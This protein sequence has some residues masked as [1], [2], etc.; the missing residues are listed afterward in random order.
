M[1]SLCPTPQGHLHN[2]QNMTKYSQLNIVSWIQPLPLLDVE[3]LSPENLD[4]FVGV[5]CHCCLSLVCARKNI[6]WCPVCQWQTYSSM[7]L[8]IS[9]VPLAH[10]DHFVFGAFG[11]LESFGSFGSF[12]RFFFSSFLSPLSPSSPGFLFLPRFSTFSLGTS[13]WLF[14]FRSS[15]L[16]ASLLALAWQKRFANVYPKVQPLTSW[17]AIRP[18]C[19]QRLCS[20]F[21]LLVSKKCNN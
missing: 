15:S 21:Y 10:S 12:G 17:K 1:R 5:C 20:A 11:S 13:G 9:M 7:P 16:L 14:S 2:G 3:W 6:S 18:T 4:L 8:W 19:F